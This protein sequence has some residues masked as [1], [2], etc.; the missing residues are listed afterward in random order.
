MNKTTS[1]TCSG[2]I[3]DNENK[4]KTLKSQSKSSTRNKNL[5]G[6][7]LTITNCRCQGKENKK[8]AFRMLKGNGFEHSLLYLARLSIRNEVFSSMQ[9]LRSFTTHKLVLKEFLQQI[10][11]KAIHSKEQSLTQIC[12]EMRL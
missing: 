8:H 10:E 7:G 1:K 3:L 6:T 9:E 12:N 4:A 2:Y 5:I 11:E